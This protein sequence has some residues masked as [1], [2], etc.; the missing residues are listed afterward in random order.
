MSHQGFDY[1]V[2]SMGVNRSEGQKPLRFAESDAEAVVGISGR[3]FGNG[4][5][6]HCLM[7]VEQVDLDVEPQKIRKCA[8]G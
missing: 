1:R 6:L 7:M 8:H 4:K 5:T 3:D 2:I